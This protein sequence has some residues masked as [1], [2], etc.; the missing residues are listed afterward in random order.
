MPKKPKP[1]KPQK[2]EP[3]FHP[4]YEAVRG[5]VH[6]EAHTG[7]EFDSNPELSEIEGKH[8]N[9]KAGLQRHLL[10]LLQRTRGGHMFHEV[11]KRINGSQES[12]VMSD[13]EVEQWW[14]F[15]QNAIEDA[16]MSANRGGGGYPRFAKR[17][18]DRYLKGK[19]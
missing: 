6:Y 9:K 7:K 2:I 5:R 18:A 12:A 17:V 4:P 11:Q 10:A 14:R 13:H 15:I 19:E 1:R 8:M 3:L 16:K